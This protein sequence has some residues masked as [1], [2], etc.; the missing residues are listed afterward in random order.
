MGYGVV[1]A[2]EVIQQME[3]REILDAEQA[4]EREEDEIKK[5]ERIKNIDEVEKQL[6]ETR[7]LLTGLR[8][9][10]AA[11]SKEDLQKKKSKKR[12]G[13]DDQSLYDEMKFARDQDI[14]DKNERLKELRTQ[15][16]ALK[17]DHVVTNKAIAYIALKKEKGNLV[18]PNDN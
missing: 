11:K 10:H 18:M 7:K 13:D 3:E 17:A 16:Q 2:D 9:E 12:G 5:N 1:T 14:N 15:L 6:Q 4:T 8:S